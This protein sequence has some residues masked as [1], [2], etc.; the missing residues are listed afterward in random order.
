MLIYKYMVGLSLASS[1]MRICVCAASIFSVSLN[2]DKY[3][4]YIRALVIYN[5]RD[6]SAARPHTLTYKINV[7]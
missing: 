2:I 1:L 6:E 4:R 5:T 7:Q 3:S